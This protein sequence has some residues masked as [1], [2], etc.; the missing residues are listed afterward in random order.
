M[1]A[2]ITQLRGIHV[3]WS[4][5]DPRNSVRIS[6][7]LRPSLRLPP[8]TVNYR[9]RLYRNSLVMG[10]IDCTLPTHFGLAPS[11]NVMLI[12]PTV[13]K[14]SLT[15]G[16]ACGMSLNPTRGPVLLARWQLASKWLSAVLKFGVDSSLISGVTCTAGG[17]WVNEARDLG[18]DTEVS[19]GL[20]GVT[21]N[22]RYALSC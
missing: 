2:D 11:V 8:I 16:W 12:K 13:I 17:E 18:I 5:S 21:L 19:W 20:R 10:A 3:Q 6:A 22:A 1:R 7:P 15:T 9:R 14:S 4:H